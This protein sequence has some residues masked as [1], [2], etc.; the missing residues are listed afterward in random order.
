ME[1]E[2]AKMVGQTDL[3]GWMNAPCKTMG[4]HKVRAP[5]WE[6]TEMKV[7]VEN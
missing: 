7:D 3:D 6:R 4:T 1:Y 5:W 2:S